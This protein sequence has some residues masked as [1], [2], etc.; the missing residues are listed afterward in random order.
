MLLLALV[1]CAVAADFTLVAHLAHRNVD[2]LE[3]LFW[4]VATP[5]DTEYLRHRSVSDLASIIGSSSS[6]IAAVSSW[7][8]SAGG[9]SVK[10]SS[11]RDTVSA[12]FTDATHAFS[13]GAHGVPRKD[14]RRPD[15][16]QFL[17]RR[18]H[19]TAVGAVR[20]RPPAVASVNNPTV[21]EI[22]EA[23]GLPVDFQATNDLTTSM[24]WGPGTFG[25][26]PSDLAAFKQQQAPLINLAKVLFD[27]PNHGVPGGDNFGEGTLDVK[28]ISAFGLNATTLVS[29]TNT[30]ASTEETTGFGVALLDFAAE[31]S[32]RPAVPHVL[33]MSLGSLSEASCDLLC[34]E[35]ATMGFTRAECDAYMATQR[36]VCMFNGTAQSDR[37]NAY[38]MALGLRGVTVLGS[39]GDGG[40]HFSF[41]RFQGGALADALNAVSCKFQ[42]PVFPT[43]SPYVLSV[44]AE[45][46]V[47]SS[48]HPVTWNVQN[49]YG[50]GGG[51]SIAFPAHAH[52]DAAVRAYLAKAGMP[53][54][55][56]FNASNRAYPD[57]SAVGVQGTSQSCPIMAGIF[58]LLMDVRLNRGLP[59][60][61]FVAP[62]IYALAAEHPGEA[63][64]DIT[65][66]NSC[67]SCDN[68][69]PATDGWDANTGFGRPVWAGLVKY[70]TTDAG[71]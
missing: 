20:P 70:L 49:T 35:V 63:F 64:E 60:L 26:L 46:W 17:V 51:F 8:R 38:F 23:Y 12:V 39:S 66:G 45:M 28:M 11:L 13:L 71:V 58:A 42:I 57:V 36:Q 68:G 32:A 3:T 61:G 16:V 50:S 33:S 44:G 29:N 18:D 56:S 30:S 10:V 6:D 9:S 7:F 1:T 65:E 52:Q 69:F 59:P 34:A 31:L 53:P 37:I 41:S 40:S 55:A 15:A 21:A 54:A 48:A 14:K 24:V 5:G 47:G 62:R 22:K 27:T 43:A 19:V 4:K 67:T 2:Q 25:Y